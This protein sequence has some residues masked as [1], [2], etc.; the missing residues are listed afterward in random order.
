M[1]KS[2]DYTFRP[3]IECAAVPT[4]RELIAF[5]P[6]LKAYP[7]FDTSCTWTV[8]CVKTADELQGFRSETRLVLFHSASINNPLFFAAVKGRVG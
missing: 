5:Y 7:Y 1:L 4:I 8:E 2:F 6:F 3:I